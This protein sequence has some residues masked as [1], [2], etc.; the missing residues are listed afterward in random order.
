MMY[1]RYYDPMGFLGPLISL[2]IFVLVLGLLVLLINFV[3]G[4]VK[5]HNKIDSV[6]RGYY[7]LISFITLAVIYFSFSDLLSLIMTSVA[8]SMGWLNPQTGYGMDAVYRSSYNPYTY[9][10]ESFA[11]AL[12]LR[13]ATLIVAIP[14][15][16]YHWATA[17]KEITTEDQE[18]RAYEVAERKKYLQIIL[19]ISTIILLVV[20]VRF[21]YL[22]LL[23]ALGVSGSTLQEFVTPCAYT[24]S[25]LSVWY[26]HLRMLKNTK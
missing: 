14:V 18:L 13:A 4:G 2:I 12:A 19:T 17:S 8:N 15:F 5:G 25:T 24:V 21:I 10:Y 20:G 1:N 6:K 26:Y 11:R 23:L 16:A 3:F 22:V 9:S 7:Y